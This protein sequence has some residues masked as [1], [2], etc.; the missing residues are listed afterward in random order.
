MM[1]EKFV[2]ERLGR[3]RTQKDVSARDMSLSMG[4]AN[5]YI[6]SIE[7]GKAMPSM[8]GLFY[9][10]EYLKISP[11]EFFDDEVSHPALVNEIVAQLKTLNE[12]NL[13]TILALTHQLQNKK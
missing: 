6:N 13:N 10:C 9:I 4:Q 3:L 5:N 11:K 1:D 2:S 12:E 8:Q 7:N